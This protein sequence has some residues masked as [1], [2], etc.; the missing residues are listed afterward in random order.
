MAAHHFGTVAGFTGDAIIVGVEQ[1]IVKLGGFAQGVGTPFDFAALGQRAAV[2]IVGVHAH[3]PERA[4]RGRVGT[5]PGHAVF[6][7]RDEA[8]AGLAALENQLGVIKAQIALLNA[9]GFA[10]AELGESSQGEER[11]QGRVKPGGGGQESEHLGGRPDGFAHGA[12]HAGFDELDGGRVGMAGQ[13]GVGKQGLDGGEVVVAGARG[14]FET[15]NPCLNGGGGV[16]QGGRGILKGV[17]AQAVAEILLM[18]RGESAGLELEQEGFHQ[19]ANRG[20]QGG[21]ALAGVEPVLRQFLERGDRLAG[22]RGGEEFP[23]FGIFGGAKFEGFAGAVKVHDAGAE[24]GEV[25]KAE[26]GVVVAAGEVVGKALGFGE[27]GGALA[28]FEAASAPVVVGPAQFK[29]DI[30][31]GARLEHA[32]DGGAGFDAQGFH[33][34]RTDTDCTDGHGFMGWGRGGI[35]R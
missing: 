28:A 34:T 15:E 3:A 30:L 16:A 32:D 23:E 4:V 27:G 24:A 29:A 26:F 33:F 19:I 13:Q 31:A 2:G 5:Q 20:L 18:A 17:L 1:G 22:A 8:S 9:D 14:D 11:D 25:G 6:R 12:E 10:G 35:D 7:K 21:V